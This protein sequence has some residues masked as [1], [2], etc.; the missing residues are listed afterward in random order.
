M[1]SQEI[2]THQRKQK[3]RLYIGGNSAET[4][5]VTTFYQDA[6]RNIPLSSQ[7][8][9]G[10]EATM[11]GNKEERLGALGLPDSEMNFVLQD[12]QKL[13]LFGPEDREEKKS[14]APRPQHSL[15]EHEIT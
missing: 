1:R 6:K 7:N 3:T 9:K 13:A 15:D 14:K 2:L 12:L 11:H 8:L 4:E 5:E 10:S